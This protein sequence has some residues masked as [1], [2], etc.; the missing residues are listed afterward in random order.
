V[1]AL[2]AA[3]KESRRKNERRIAYATTLPPERALVS[4][5]VLIA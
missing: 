2:S 3:S 4:L 5:I 1:L